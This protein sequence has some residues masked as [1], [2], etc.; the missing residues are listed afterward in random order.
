MPKVK[1]AQAHRGLWMYQSAAIFT[2]SVS[3]FLCIVDVAA[4][5][6]FFI[7]F[8]RS[9]HK[10]FVDTSKRHIHDKCGNHSSCSLTLLMRIWVRISHARRMSKK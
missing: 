5:V 8:I 9:E 7:S 1:T 10:L 6:I 2:H 3:Q 4:V